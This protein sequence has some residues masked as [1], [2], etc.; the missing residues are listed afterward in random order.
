MS[1][2]EEWIDDMAIQAESLKILAGLR[3]ELRAWQA[4]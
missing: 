2:G 4:D 3:L 1:M